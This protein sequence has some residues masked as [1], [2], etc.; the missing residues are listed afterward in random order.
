MI[1]SL[2][3][4]CLKVSLCVLLG[5]A[6]AGRATE[7]PISPEWTVTVLDEHGS[8]REGIKVVQ[9]WSYWTVLETQTEVKTTDAM[10]RIVFAPRATSANAV[11]LGFARF[12][13]KLPHAGEP[14]PI[15]EIQLEERAYKLQRGY[16]NL[17]AGYLA[18]P[19][20]DAKTSGSPSGL[21]TTFR[22]VPVD[23]VDVLR[24]FPTP[25]NFEQAKEILAANP[26]SART[27]DDSG[28]T[29]LH[30]LIGDSPEVVEMARL[31]VMAGA[32][33]NAANREGLT[34][35]HQAA[36]QGAWQNAELFLQ[37]GAAVNARTH[38][39]KYSNS[40]LGRTPLH[41]AISPTASSV[42]CGRVIEVLI[43]H[44]ADVN[45]QDSTGKTP[46]HL[47]APFG[48]DVALQLLLS[49][50]ASVDVLDDEGETPL[51]GAASYGIPARIKALLA[52]GAKRDIRNKDGL[53]PIDL[54]K[55]TNRSENVD[56]LR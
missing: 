39:E 31:L 8:P 47:A 4:A 45:A 20:Q 27:V 46:L 40:G 51:F 28:R 23:L 13:G 19:T 38:G 1:P 32:D 56:A 16:Y 24:R 14:E 43:R 17:E 2:K 41:S 52:A 29:A 18:P 54:A 50:G 49:S 25:D 12:L 53:L 37:H 7:L 55:K 42:N 9:T 22:L 3:L 21:S 44:G 10:G 34:P 6:I 33:V 26:A 48:P 36:Q 15:V 30:H 11:K 35:L 5:S